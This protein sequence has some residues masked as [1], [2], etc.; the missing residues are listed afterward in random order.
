MKMRSKVVL[1]Y[2][3]KVF[4][5]VMMKEWHR[6]QTQSSTLSR[7]G[8]TC[9]TSTFHVDVNLW[10]EKQSMTK[11]KTQISI[12]KPNHNLIIRRELTA[13]DLTL[14]TA[15]TSKRWNYSRSFCCHISPRRVL[16]APG[17]VQLL[18]HSFRWL[19]L[20]RL[21]FHTSIIVKLMIWTLF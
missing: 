5:F 13:R 1:L 17:P 19:Y 20:M 4:Y 16:W 6:F 14:D 3:H 8:G 7:Y 2:L 11:L 15:R 21:F 18:G 10:R 9:R 12:V